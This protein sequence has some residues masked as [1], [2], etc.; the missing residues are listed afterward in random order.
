[1]R[2]ILLPLLAVLAVPAPRAAAGGVELH[3]R[4]G[5]AMRLLQN[6]A[7][8]DAR[9][10][11]EPLLVEAPGDPAVQ[12]VAGILRL[13]E[14]RYAEAVPLLEAAEQASPDLAGEY[15][16]LARNARDVTKGHVRAEGKHFVVSTA[17]G[18]DEVLVP[19]VLEAL[20][21]Q[22]RA[23]EEDL[24]YAP[25]G[26]VTVEFLDGTRALARLSTL[27]EEEIKTS[28]TIA[29]CKFNKMMIVSPRALLRGYEWLD[30]AA[31]EYTHYVVTRRTRNQAPIWLHE[32]IAKWEETRWRG[33]GGEAL[34]PFAAA[35]LK[36]AA[37]RGRLIG[38]AEMHPSMAK[39]PSQEAA[40]LAFA[41]VAVAVEYLQRQGGQP[42]MNRILDEVRGG[43]G[44]EEA[45][46]AA[47]GA[48]FADFLAGW[49]R[50]IAARPL[51]QGGDTELQRLRFKGD[52]RHGGTHSEW[53][54]I[55][56]ERARA[57][58]RL[59]E[60][61]RERGR[62]EAARLEYGKAVKRVGSA[63]HP[64]LADKFALASM[65][66]GRDGDAEAA[67]VEA[68]RSHPHYAALHV[69]LGRLE[70]RH[71][72]WGNARDA[73]L[74]ANQVDP[75]DPEIHAGLAQALDALG[76]A[77]GASR[78]KRFA[79]ILVGRTE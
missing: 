62:W 51:P 49:K 60:I 54:E 45:L 76:D 5:E 59:G 35:L 2:P 9:A 39:L 75:F 58:A 23:L 43:R 16:A 47:T 20:E 68:T 1:M 12:L 8:E 78:E 17:K 74:Q 15:L 72:Q 46:A 52:P 69:H 44:A 18:K 29:I 61:F 7:V 4:L 63:R 33:A 71:S 14:Q 28:G 50:Y 24:G 64:V 19:Y 56:D 30:T 65:M 55:P 40:A 25:P 77:A 3:R 73:F 21:A 66:A 27:G 36:D 42:L 38:F 10:L 57:W 48:P 6:E 26:K 37:R 31:H 34:S 32:G 70:L 53:S 79:E 11:V 67:L 41:E 22:R 13:E